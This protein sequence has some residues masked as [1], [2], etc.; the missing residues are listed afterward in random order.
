M[1]FAIAFKV[2]KDTRKTLIAQMLKRIDKPGPALKRIGLV[3]EES[4][5]TNFE[6][7][8]R[9]RKWKQSK[10]SRNT[11]RKTLSPTGNTIKTTVTSNVRGKKLLLGASSF[12]AAYHH[13]GFKKAVSIKQHTRTIKSG[14]SVLVKAHKIKQNNP[15]RPFIIWQKEDIR[16]AEKILFEYDTGP[17]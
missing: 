3:G 8:G 16:I 9:P 12:I 14:K 17:R 2:E 4:V 1:A 13:F 7:E 11:G 10:R 15:K 5:A 6:R